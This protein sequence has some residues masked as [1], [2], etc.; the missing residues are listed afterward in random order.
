MHAYGA[1]EVIVVLACEM[2]CYS[3]SDETSALASARYNLIIVISLMML[4]APC[5]VL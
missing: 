3:T 2:D 5:A 4:N 1:V